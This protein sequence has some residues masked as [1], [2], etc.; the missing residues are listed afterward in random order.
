MLKKEQ[1]KKTGAG[2]LCGKRGKWSILDREQGVE[3]KPGITSLFMV[4]FHTH[5]IELKKGRQVE[6]VFV[7]GVSM[8]AEEREKKRLYTCTL[9]EA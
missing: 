9:R 8:F 4:H 7:L 6:G 3:S 2:V 1:G 5:N